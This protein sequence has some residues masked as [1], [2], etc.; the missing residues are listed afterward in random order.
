MDFV[1]FFLNKSGQEETKKENENKKIR[2]KE[3]SEQK[4]KSKSI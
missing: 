1:F 2:A 3:M 4:N